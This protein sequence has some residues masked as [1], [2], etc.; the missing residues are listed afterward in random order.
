MLYIVFYYRYFAFIA[1]QSKTKEYKCF[2]Y[3]CQ[4][5]SKE[6]TLALRKYS[7]II[8]DPA[9]IDKN[10]SFP[11]NSSASS[12]SSNVSTSVSSSV[13]KEADDSICYSVLYL[14][15]LRIAL[16]NELEVI[17]H[18]IVKLLSNIS[19]AV[20]VC[21]TITPSC[22]SIY[23]RKNNIQL[24]ETRVRFVS[25]LGLS[26]DSKC[27]GYITGDDENFFC[28]CF[29]SETDCEQLTLSM[30]KACE[31]RSNR[32]IDPSTHNETA[33]ISTK[34]TQ[35]T[36]SSN[37]KESMSEF[38]K[39]KI[40]IVSK[41]VKSQKYLSTKSIYG[42]YQ[43]QYYGTAPVAIANDKV[44]VQ[45]AISYLENQSFRLSSP[46][47]IDFQIS[48]GGFSLIDKD[49]KK[50][51]KKNFPLTTVQYCLKKGHS[52]AFVIKDSKSGLFEAYAM[53]EMNSSASQIIE[54]IQK[55]V[56]SK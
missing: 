34:S 33:K 44:A 41:G 15:C 24:F 2:V 39:S 31:H 21:I 36:A 1:R 4:T 52:I 26:E 17:R 5:S 16:I 29:S 50:F 22:F 18:A 11:E 10:E 14:G 40:S 47:V 23:E 43:V 7:D 12:I 32:T 6:L 9:K 25:F 54:T 48:Q 37:K 19:Q 13:H 20:E 45:E 46:N 51:Y 3:Q 27:C 53:G 42:I 30:K 35:S 28:H 38:I 49:K 56:N 8:L 55:A